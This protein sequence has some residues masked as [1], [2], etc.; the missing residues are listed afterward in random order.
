ALA[1]GQVLAQFCACP[2]GVA[3]C[4]ATGL[5]IV[6]EPTSASTAKINVTA[7]IT[8]L[9]KAYDGSTSAA[10]ATCTPTGVAGHGAVACPPRGAAF[11][12]ACGGPGQTVPA[13]G[14]LPGVDAGKYKL[15]ASTAST[16]ANITAATV[17]ASITAADKPYDGSPS[18]TITTCSLTGVI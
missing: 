7:S 12:P 2:G 11:A 3:S 10:I 5:A 6:G 18:A 15:A 13:P 14:A 8:A 17:T 1:D 4:R 16:P 9:D